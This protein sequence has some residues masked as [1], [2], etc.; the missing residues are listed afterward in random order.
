MDIGAWGGEK[1]Q[2]VKRKTQRIQ[3]FWKP[4]EEEVATAPGFVMRADCVAPLDLAAQMLLA[5]L[6]R[7]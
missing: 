3:E 5:P 1:E 4:R 2:L 7:Q 6:T